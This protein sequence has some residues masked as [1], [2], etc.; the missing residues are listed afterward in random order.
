M[1]SYFC[2]YTSLICNRWFGW[3]TYFED[4]WNNLHKHLVLLVHLHKPLVLLNKHFDGIG[5]SP[6]N[7]DVGPLP[8][9]LEKNGLPALTCANGHWQVWL[10]CLIVV[11]DANQDEYDEERRSSCLPTHVYNNAGGSWDLKNASPITQKHGIWRYP[12]PWRGCWGFCFHTLHLKCCKK[13]GWI[14]NERKDKD[15]RQYERSTHS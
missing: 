13:L 1:K 11:V 8:E 9:L 6:L 15:V 4:A 5:K 3:W 10:V 12:T 2:I 7:H 14:M